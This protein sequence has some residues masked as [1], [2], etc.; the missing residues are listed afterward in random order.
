M[1]LVLGVREAGGVAG[2]FEHELVLENFQFF[3]GSVES[4][5]IGYFLGSGCGLGN[6]SGLGGVG[7]VVHDYFGV[8]QPL[9][10]SAFPCH[11][12]LTLRSSLVVLC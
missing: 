2:G 10:E 7:K 4:V 8:G 1:Q 6:R 3:S 5:G 9:L 11:V 12:L